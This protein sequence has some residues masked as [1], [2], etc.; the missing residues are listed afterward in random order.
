M[1]IGAHII[2]KT[3]ASVMSAAAWTTLVPG[4]VGTQTLYDFAARHGI[5]FPDGAVIDPADLVRLALDGLER[6]E[7]EILDPLATEAKASLAGPPR[8]FA[9]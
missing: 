1:W 5:E 4:L 2:K 6:G 7:I 9:L 3:S 8:S